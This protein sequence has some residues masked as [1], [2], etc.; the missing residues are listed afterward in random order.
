MPCLYFLIRPEDG[1]TRIM[2]RRAHEINAFDL[3][4]DLKSMPMGSSYLA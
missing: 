2:Y 1:L 3:V 4:K